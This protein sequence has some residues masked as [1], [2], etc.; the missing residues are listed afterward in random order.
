MKFFYQIF[1]TLYPLAAKLISGKN[2]KAKLWVAGR[3]NIFER[4]QDAFAN[5]NAKVVWV[6]CSSLGEFE[7]GRPVI[8]TLKKDNP[9]VKVLVTF[10]SPSGYEIRKNYPLADWVFYLPMDGAANANRFFDIV[11]PSVV[12]FVKYEFWYYYLK[13][14]NNRNIPIILISAVFRNNQPFFKWYGGFNRK[15]LGF[16][17]MLFVQNEESVQLLNS[18]GVKDNVAISGDTRFDSVLGNAQKFEPIPEIETFIGNHKRVIVAGSTWLEDDEVLYHYAKMHTHVMFII[19][20]HD[21]QKSRIDECIELYPGA[22]KYSDWLTA[23]PLPLTDTKV[24]FTVN[25]R[26]STVNNLEPNIIIIDNIGMLSRLYK[27][28]TICFVGGGFGEDGVHN[29]LE[30]AVYGKPVIIGPEYSKFVEAEGLLSARGGF[31]VEST[32]EIERIIN[33]L[34]ND[35]TLYQD[36]CNA[37]GDYVAINAGATGIITKYIYEKRLL[38]N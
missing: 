33:K 7:Q 10:F 8:E 34:F 27:Y 35:N 31:S 1:I 26:P 36:V 15:M 14:A 12:L 30:A 2:A 21:V 9:S 3:E 28:A 38:T 18:I 19:A 32:M 25:G 16:F 23:N 5:N 29:V 17:T 37:A 22:I 24:E 13:E 4:L 6:H 20:P 11:K